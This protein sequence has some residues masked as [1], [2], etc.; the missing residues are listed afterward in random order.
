MK[1]LS[2]I[3]HLPF[4]SCVL[5]CFI[6]QCTVNTTGSEVE[7]ER[8]LVYNSDGTPAAGAA[9]KIVPVGFIPG[10][11]T[12]N[13]ID[14][15]VYSTQTDKNGRY[16]VDGLSKGNYNIVA[17][18]SSQN[19]FQDSVYIN[20]ST[21]TISSDTL[22]AP[23]SVT[24]IV[25]LQPNH[26]PRTV[27]VQA[28]GTLSYTNVDAQGRFTISN[29][30]AG[31]YSFRLVTTEEGYTPTFVPITVKAGLNDTLD[32]TLWLIY[33]GIPSVTGL[34]AVFDTVNATVK[35]SWNKTDYRD[36][37]TYLIYR[38]NAT[39]VTLSTTP[40][41]SVTDTAC[42]ERPL[43][44]PGIA[45]IPGTISFVNGRMTLKGID[46]VGGYDTSIPFAQIDSAI[47]A[48]IRACTAITWNYRI[49]IRNNSSIEGSPY[50][51]AAVTEVNAHIARSHF[52]ADVRTLGSNYASD[53]ISPNDTAVITMRVHNIG[54]LL[55][56][57]QVNDLTS[58]TNIKTKTK[59]DTI[60]L[61]N[62]TVKTVS[63][64]I[65]D[66]KIEYRVTD[67]GGTVW[68]D[69]VVIHVMQVV[70]SIDSINLKNDSSSNFAIIPINVPTLLKAYVKVPFGHTV[71]YA[72]DI[73]NK[74]VFTAV[75]KPEITI[76]VKDTLTP[77]YQCV[78]R[79]TDSISGVRLDTIHLETRIEWEKTAIINFGERICSPIIR[80]DSIYLFCFEQKQ[81]NQ[82]LIQVWKSADGI[83]WQKLSD[84]CGINSLYDL[85]VYKNKFFATTYTGNG[86][87][88]GTYKIT[89]CYSDNGINWT[90]LPPVRS[91]AVGYGTS[92]L[93]SYNDTL[94][95][96]SELYDSAN[97][98]FEVID[99]FSTNGTSF[100]EID[101]FV[102]PLIS[103][104]VCVNSILTRKEQL[105]VETNQM[106]GGPAI[107]I[108]GSNTDEGGMYMGDRYLNMSSLFYDDAVLF[109]ETINS[110]S[111]LYYSLDEKCE[112][113]TLSNSLPGSSMVVHKN[114]IFL[115]SADGVWASK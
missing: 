69:T 31:D 115:F 29:L 89:V 111:Q 24:A 21:E 100:S 87:L 37:Q 46:T 101:Y 95:F 41:A 103:S 80:N 53:T 71:S 97:Q 66:K 23:G 51:F 85:T 14:D 26:D 10:S 64:S 12:Q 108:Y 92:R 62:D 54:R 45:S 36:F 34:H 15:A 75:E 112:I 77:D 93:L 61:I 70:P 91:S 81:V 58:G 106:C 110:I 107:L 48:E 3:T 96:S 17:E 88:E 57:I 72:W 84:S 86:L 67:N 104:S 102:S 1:H 42:E 13:D 56:Q 25:G 8:T 63:A 43:S 105:W 19:S 33:T 74:G 78:L 83:T 99:Y 109:K 59:T 20:G 4:S 38:D 52:I 113:H 98:P 73:G 82:Y 49:S 55:T 60:H 16:S 47:D 44:L 11:S 32:D 39:D 18:L 65:G 40:I 2:V 94:W 35:L 90:K 9:V 27:T 79:M 28:L 6:Y 7:N 50:G 5:L 22:G 68:I 76:T 114:K 30:A